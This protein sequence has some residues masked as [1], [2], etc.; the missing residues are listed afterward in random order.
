MQAGN[1]SIHSTSIHWAP[2]LCCALCWALGG[3]VGGLRP[4]P[5][6]RNPH[7]QK[8]R[9]AEGA[10]STPPEACPPQGKCQTLEKRQEAPCHEGGLRNTLAAQGG[11]VLRPGRHEV[12]PQPAPSPQGPTTPR[13]LFGLVHNDHSSAPAPRA[14]AHPIPREGW[15]GGVLGGRA[16]LPAGCG[17]G[18]GG[19]LFLHRRK[20]TARPRQVGGSPL[21]HF[22]A[23]QRPP[24]PPSYGSRGAG[25]KEAQQPDHQL[26]PPPHTNPGRKAPSPQLCPPAVTASW[27][28]LS[29]SLHL[30]GIGAD[31]L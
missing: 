29:P 28:R 4:N 18:R 13:V 20:G 25:S 24:P 6:W 19:C 2:P 27:H 30:S 23:P 12:R 17:E 31:R 8:A 11:A 1:P 5:T 14:P 21:A 15:G 16:L 26:L 22:P 10:K 7:S 3:G 9:D